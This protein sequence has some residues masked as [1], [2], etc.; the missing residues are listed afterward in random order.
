MKDDVKAKEGDIKG[1][2]ARGVQGSGNVASICPQGERH[3]VQIKNER[4]R[5][6]MEAT[7][8]VAILFWWPVFVCPNL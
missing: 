3:N 4:R 5:T 6:K 8:L 1:R 2:G 7:N